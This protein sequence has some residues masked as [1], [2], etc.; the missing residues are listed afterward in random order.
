MLNRVNIGCGMTPTP[1]W[2]NYDNSFS[3]LLSRWP[4]WLIRLLR[5]AGF[6]NEGSFSYL[7]F[8]RENSI[9]FCDAVKRIPLPDNSVD[10]VYSSHMLEHLDDLEA[11]AF[12]KE[13]YRVLTK[14]GIIR[15]AVPGL[16]AKIEQYLGDKDADQFIQSLYTCVRKPRTLLARLKFV[17]VG[18]RH[19]HWVYDEDSLSR[20]QE[21]VGYR[22]A[23]SLLPG[24][25]RILNPGAL[26][27]AERVEESI[28]V[29]AI[30]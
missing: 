18:P 16:S 21:S 30:K 17:I 22:D 11:R 13:A 23:I 15:I 4:R 25:T 28:F 9:S 2:R 1:G 19:H 12:L 7:S 10:V 14:D 26:N 5:N 6:F 29:E 8:C 3:L 27:L 24:Q 20:L